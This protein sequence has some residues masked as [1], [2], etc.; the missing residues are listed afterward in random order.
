[1]GKIIGTAPLNG[2]SAQRIFRGRPRGRLGTFGSGN[3]RLRVFL[4][5]TVGTT[6]LIFDHQNGT[7]VI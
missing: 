1:M 7:Q 6:S 5:I 2:E 4:I 3:G